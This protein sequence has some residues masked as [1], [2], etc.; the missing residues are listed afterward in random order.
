MKLN[1][2]ELTLLDEFLGFV[3]ERGFIN[4]DPQTLEVLQSIQNKTKTDLEDFWRPLSE[5][6]PLHLKVIVKDIET[7]E[8]REMIRKE[9]ADS[10]SP[11]SMVM[12]HDDEAETLWTAHY[13]WRLP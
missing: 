2:S 1:F 8:E 11:A 7:G 5:L 6:P 12:H 4:V 9:Y 13:K 10:Y 3:A